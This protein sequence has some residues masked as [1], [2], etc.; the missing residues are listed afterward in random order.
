MKST[1]FV[2]NL[3]SGFDFPLENQ[4][5][6][7]TINRLSIKIQE[8][9]LIYQIINK[10]SWEL[11]LNVSNIEILNYLSNSFIKK[12]LC[13]DIKNSTN[14]EILILS[15]KG[16]NSMLFPEDLSIDLQIFPLKINIDQYFLEFLYE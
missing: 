12:T 13:K 4:E 5:K 10:I 3:Y 1:E 11:S 8:L 7:S 15:L 16:N 9:S 2:I 14:K 6:K